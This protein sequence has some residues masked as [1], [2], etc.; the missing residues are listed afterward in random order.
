MKTKSI[1]FGPITY[2]II[3]EEPDLKDEHYQALKGELGASYHAHGMIY[4]CDNQSP[5]QE[6]VTVV[7]ESLHCILEP[8]NVL[9]KNKE[10][11]VVTALG[12]G[13]VAWMKD[14]PG[15]VGE[16]MGYE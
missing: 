3:H 6:L 16:I 7:H 14:N 11:K 2:Q 13:V 15:L 4:V 10:E 12:F 5:D 8:Y 1:K 9:S